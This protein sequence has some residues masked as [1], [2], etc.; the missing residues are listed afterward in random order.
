MTEIK[1]ETI[2]EEDGKKF[3]EKLEALLNDGFKLEASSVGY[4]NSNGDYNCDI[5][6]ALLVKK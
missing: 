5:W 1:V 3:K 4:E 2:K 6:Q